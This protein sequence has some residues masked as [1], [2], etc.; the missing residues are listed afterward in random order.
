[1]GHD[2]HLPILERLTR[3]L[4]AVVPGVGRPGGTVFLPLLDDSWDEKALREWV[5]RH[6]GQYGLDPVWFLTGIGRPPADIRATTDPDAG[7]MP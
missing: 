4:Q 6:H 1:M 7:S 3:T 5:L 2:T